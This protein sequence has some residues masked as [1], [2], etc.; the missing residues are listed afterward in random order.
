MKTK[1]V[2]LYA[3]VSTDT[4]TTENQLLQLRSVAERHGWTIVHECVF[5]RNVTEVS[6][7]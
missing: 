2:A 5:R 7:G 1:R 4:Q 3:R 6:D